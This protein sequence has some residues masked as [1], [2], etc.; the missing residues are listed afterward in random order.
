MNRAQ[1]LNSNNPEIQDYLASASCEDELS[2]SREVTNDAPDAYAVGSSTTINFPCS[3]AAGNPASASATLSVI[4]P[5][6]ITGLTGSSSGSG[7]FIATAAY[8]TWLAP[9]VQVLRDFRDRHLLTNYP[10]TL[11]V[12]SY[13]QYSPPIADEIA[14]S[15]NL[16]LAT[17]FMLTPLVYA[18]KFPYLASLMLLSGLLLLSGMLKNVRR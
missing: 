4:E 7:C 8:G 12:E 13:Y 3:D 2:G 17:R 14:S 16:A 15:P 5:P 9:E 1:I 11:F 6:T 10:G 18:V